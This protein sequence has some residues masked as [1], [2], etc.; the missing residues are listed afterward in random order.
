MPADLAQGF[1]SKL[2]GASVKGARA[3]CRLVQNLTSHGR[4]RLRSNRLRISAAGSPFVTK[5]KF[6]HPIVTFPLQDCNGAVSSSPYS[7]S[8]ND[9]K[10]QKTTSL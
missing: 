6:C 9:G 1:F 4:A 7:E 5:K 10:I 2:S 3:A 8:N